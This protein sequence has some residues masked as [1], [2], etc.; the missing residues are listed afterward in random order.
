MAFWADLY[1]TWV[2]SGEL[3]P[4]SRKE[5]KKEI[6]GAGVA[7]PDAIQ[8]IRQMQDLMGTGRLQYKLRDSNDFIDL[9]SITHRLSRYKEYER[10]RSIPEIEN[11]LTTFA[12]ESCIA[13]DTKIATPFGFIPISEL[14]QTRK[15]GK[16][17]VYCWDFKK[18]DYSLGWAYNPRIVKKEKT[19]VVQL[20]KGNGQFRA[21]ADHR[22]LLKNRKWTTVGELKKGDEIM[23]FYRIKPYKVYNRARSKAFPRIFTFSSGFINEKDF[24][25]EWKTGIKQNEYCYKIIRLIASGAKTRDIQKILGHHWVNLGDRIRYNGFNYY[26]CQDFGKYPDHFKVSTTWEG[27]EENV[28]DLSVEEHENFCTNVGVFHNCQIGENGHMFEVKTSNEE[29]KKE[30][31]SL[32]FSPHFLNLDE[33]L[34]SWARDLYLYGDHFIELI[35]DK[36]DPKLGILK[37][38]YLP[39]ESMFRIETVKG[40]LLEF[41]QAKDRPDHVSIEKSNVLDASE[42]EL[43]GTSAIRFAPNS[44]VHFRVGGNR[45]GFAPYGVSLIEPARGPAHQ[46]KMME[47][48]MLVYRLSRSPERRVFY[49]DVGTLPPFKAEAFIDRVKDQY[50]K[51]KVFNSRGGGTGASAVEEKWSP[52]SIEEDFWIPLRPNSNTRV[53]TL[54][55]AQALGEIDDSLYFRNKLFNSMNFPKN[56]MAQEDPSVTKSTLSQINVT[57]AK[58]IERLQRSLANGICDIGIRHLTLMGYPQELFEDLQIQM[59][60]PSHY[61]ELM[62]NEIKDARVN[63][64]TT[65]KNSNMFSDYDLMVDEYKLS[66]EVAKEKISRTMIQKLQE[67]KLQ[68]MSQNPQLLGIKAPSPNAPNDIGTESGG[69]NPQMGENPQEQPENNTSELDTESESQNYGPLPEPSEDDLKTYDL[70]IYDYSKGI[71]EEEI[72]A[73]E[74]D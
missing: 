42:T 16:F 68:V 53:E 30:L 62:E 59:T 57:F 22:I 74:V 55:G 61:R 49:I 35:I 66:P 56:Y 20:T 69:P 50:R 48:A 24:T 39:P 3:D 54:P 36:D 25:E 6:E 34:Y 23:P 14:E 31:E 4:I 71:D 40:K 12:D 65:L 37:W 58:L 13:G 29:I 18:D 45:K 70:E 9:T 2:Y 19:I 33:N 21:T 28:Y 60:P 64:I 10:I 1:K 5:T 41:Q 63:R 11:A 44:I 51:K 27:P 15:E 38:G 32:Y 47:D 43:A 73:S 17:L 8:D 46:L 7:V 26:E 52:Q 67:L 72:D